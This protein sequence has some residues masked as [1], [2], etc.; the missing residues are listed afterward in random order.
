MSLDWKMNRESAT[1]R[2]VMNPINCL[3]S[4]IEVRLHI[5]MKARHFIGLAS[6]PLLVIMNPNEFPSWMPNVH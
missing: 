5:L 4:F 1:M 3:T 2:P 6:I